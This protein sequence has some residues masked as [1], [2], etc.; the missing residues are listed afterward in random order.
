MQQIKVRRSLR[1]RKV[2]SGKNKKRLYTG[3]LAAV[4]LITSGP[5]FIRTVQTERTQNEL[6]QETLEATAQIAGEGNVII[7]DLEYID[8]TVGDYYY[9]GSE[10]IYVDDG[11]LPALKKGKDYWLMLSD[12]ISPEFTAQL[13]IQGYTFKL[14]LENGSLGTHPVKVYMLEESK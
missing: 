13:E 11:V 7:T 9:P 12:F 14:L 10:Q 3:L 4:L 2:N 6:L 5:K 8:W 1:K